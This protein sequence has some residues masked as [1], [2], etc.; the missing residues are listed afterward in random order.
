MERQRIFLFAE[1]VCEFF[2]DG[3]LSL[4]IGEALCL[5]GL[6]LGRSAVFLSTDVCGE[7]AH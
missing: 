3:V 7:K 5:K 6:T 2:K 4:K 1:F